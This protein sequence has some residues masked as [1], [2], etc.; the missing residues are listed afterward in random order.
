VTCHLYRRELLRPARVAVS[1]DPLAAVRDVILASA[2]SGQ[3][4]NLL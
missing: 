2:R 3:G 1:V 4:N